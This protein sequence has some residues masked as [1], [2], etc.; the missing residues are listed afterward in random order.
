MKNSL[1]IIMKMPIVGIFIFISRE[2][3]MFSRVKHEKRFYNLGAWFYKRC[4]QEPDVMD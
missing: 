3:F 2:N 1:L 4:I